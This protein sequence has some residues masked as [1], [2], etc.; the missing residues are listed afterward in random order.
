MAIQQSDRTPAPDQEYDRKTFEHRYTT[1]MVVA[2]HGP[3][4][5]E[6]GKPVFGMV[7]LKTTWAEYEASFHHQVARAV[8]IEFGCAPTLI[9][10][11]DQEDMPIV[12][13]HGIARVGFGSDSAAFGTLHIFNAEPRHYDQARLMSSPQ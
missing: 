1:V 8:L 13:K 7:N 12:L 5:L 2:Q 11:C 4:D 6:N 9:V 10:C 3:H